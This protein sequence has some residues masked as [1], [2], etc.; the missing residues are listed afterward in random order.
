[1]NAISCGGG[2][3]RK[4]L[5]NSENP[6]NP[7]KPPPHGN[8]TRRA[9]GIDQRA[10]A[11]AMNG[12]AANATALL[13]YDIGYAQPLNPPL[14]LFASARTDGCADTRFP[15]TASRYNVG[16]LRPWRGT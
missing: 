11:H 8:R 16:R 2:I 14:L 12:L 10:Y 13:R 3:D 7:L 9:G 1:M 4:Q 15:A 6:R 5:R